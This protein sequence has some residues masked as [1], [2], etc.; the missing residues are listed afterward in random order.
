MSRTF[1]RA[2]KAFDL[3]EVRRSLLI[4]GEVTANCAQCGEMGL[5]PKKIALCPNC[6][7]TF[8]Y[9][10]SRRIDSNPG[11]RFQYAARMANERP[12]LTLI[13]LTD[14]QKINSSAKARDLL[15]GS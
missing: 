10:A 14:F 6:G 13:D 1:L 7:A 8:R 9:L 5:D 15:G 4:V 11:E 2:Y 3:E 12:D